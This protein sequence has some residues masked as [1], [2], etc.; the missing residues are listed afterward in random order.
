MVM[1]RPPGKAQKIAEKVMKG[2]GIKVSKPRSMQ[3]G[4]L[5]TPYLQH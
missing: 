4:K 1:L 2:K 3:K 5:D